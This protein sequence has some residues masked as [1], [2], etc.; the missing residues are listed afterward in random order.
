VG[1]GFEKYVLAIQKFCKTF[2]T[3]PEFKLQVDFDIMC[4]GGHFYIVSDGTH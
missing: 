1:D 3:S 2:I 4:D